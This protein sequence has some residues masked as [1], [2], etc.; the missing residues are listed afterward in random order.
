MCCLALT[1]VGT[2]TCQLCG[3]AVPTMHGACRSHSTAWCAAYLYGLH[4]LS[5]IMTPRRPADLAVPPHACRYFA[6]IADERMGPEDQ[7]ILVTQ[8][9]R[10]RARVHV[11]GRVCLMFGIAVDTGLPCE[12]GH[13]R[14][15]GPTWWRSQRQAIVQALC[16]S[17]SAGAGQPCS[18]SR[19]LLVITC[20]WGPASG[21]PS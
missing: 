12:R 17:P 18:W 21:V 20:L 3:L 14:W 19:A 16:N 10:G 6:R 2:C 8:Q 13:G 7:C 9:L 11:A 5:S 1:G 4:Y 15:C